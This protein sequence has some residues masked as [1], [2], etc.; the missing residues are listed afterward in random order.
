MGGA[1]GFLRQVLYKYV[2][3]EL[4]ERPKKRFGVPIDQWRRGQ[5]RDWAED[6]PSIRS[7]AQHGLLEVGSIRVKW[8]EHLSGI[9]NWQFVLWDILVFQDWFSQN[10]LV[11]QGAGPPRQKNM[12]LMESGLCEG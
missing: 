10:K 11:R 8:Q 7:L 9:R 3:P 6:L 5:L 4:V 1:S 2:P 12:G